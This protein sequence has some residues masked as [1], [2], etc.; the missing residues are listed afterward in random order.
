MNKPL[1]LALLFPLAGLSGLAQAQELSQAQS[2]LIDQYCSKC[3]NL[4]DF[5]GSLAFELVNHEQVYEDAAVWEKVIRKL[6]AGMMPPPG[7]ERPSAAQL[8]AL[9]NELATTIDAHAAASPAPG[10]PLLRRLNRTEYQSAIRDLLD[11]PIDA[12]ELMPADDSSGGFDNVANVLSISP[13]LLESYISAASKVSRLA[14]GDMNTVAATTTYRGDGQ[15]QTL[16]KEG[17]ALGTRGGLSVQH[18]FPLDAEYEINVVRTVPNVAFELAPFGEADPIEVVVDGKRVA[19]VQPQ[20]R[21]TI[22]LTLNGGLHQVDAA[23][24]PL[25]AALGVDD[26]HSVWATS[27]G[28][29]TLSIRGPLEPTG[30]GD[31]A[32]R[33]KIFVCQP[34]AVNQEA[35]CA[36][37]ILRQLATRAYRKPVNQE[38]LDILLAFFADGRAKGNFDTG[39]Q[40][41]LSRLLVDPQF[42]FRFE[43][44]PEEL[45]PGA[46]FA[47]GD[48]EL[49]SRLS[50]FLWSS[51]PD[52]RLLELAGQ[53]KLKDA[54]VLK[55]EVQRMLAD[56]KA[57]SLTTNFATQWLSLRRL[58]TANPVSADFDNALR[59][60]ML[61]ETQLL[62]GNVLHEDASIVDFLDADYTFVNERLA[63]HYGLPGIRGSHFRKVQL[64]NEARRGL[65]GHASILTITSA[66]NRTSPVIRGSWV[67]ENLLGTP[68]PAPPPGVETNL[69]VSVPGGSRTMTV[70]E[71][72]ERHRADPSCAACH[73]VIDP[74]GFALENYDAIGKWR[75]EV[76]GAAINTASTLWD[77]NPIEGPE[78]LRAALLARE[79]M[80]VEAFIEKMLTYA[81]GRRVEYFDMPAVRA[82]AKAA[83]AQDYRMSAIVQGIVDSPAFR[84][85]T[86]AEQD[87][88]EVAAATTN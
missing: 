34:E 51:I 48:Y 7:N 53:G 67:L 60:A 45:A 68:P 12:T 80:F 85:R 37:R 87:Q 17:L 76:G 25:S 23:F 84:M 55:S 49:A 61:E 21:G 54:T 13:V 81:L 42:I 78:G 6:S 73:S 72:L 26:L 63:Q 38:S 43:A 75:D 82:I 14:V 88:A 56:P 58:A 28:I 30:P 19:L 83:Q 10:A 33:R 64:P 36:E 77:G 11:L 44:E 59:E 62:F 35:A 4:D 29:N 79:D 65:L 40:Y 15:S 70:R 32:S 52:E 9:M 18:V 8:S 27:T 47:V 24:L 39:I 22:R 46:I 57:D 2:E 74:L 1:Y 16:H 5:S 86:K 20:D 66:P 69:E 50:F 3:H 31:T 71:Q 41:A